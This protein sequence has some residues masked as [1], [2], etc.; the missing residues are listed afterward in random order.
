MN[1]ERF[2]SLGDNCE[3]GFVLRGVGL[4]VG[5]FFRWCVTPPDV[6]ARVFQSDFQDVYRFENLVPVHATMVRDLG[7]GLCFHSSMASENQIF[8]QPVEE[9]RA[10]HAQELEKVNYLLAKLRARLSDPDV[11]F[12]YKVNAGLDEGQK[13]QIAQ[14][15]TGKAKG[16]LL[17]VGASGSDAEAPGSVRERAPRVYEGFV[18]RFAPYS[19][20]DDVSQRTWERLLATADVLA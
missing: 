15:V 6:L 1:P 12:I 17:F 7:S 18:D 11:I 4:D 20:A 9:R 16:S 5:S 3:L 8:T 13:N 2:E 14:Q 19:Q 10:V